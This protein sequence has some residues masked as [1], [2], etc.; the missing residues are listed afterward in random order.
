M[1][2]HTAQERKIK[3]LEKQ[4]EITIADYIDKEDPM[5]EPLSPGYHLNGFD[6]PDMYFIPQ[7]LSLELHVALW[8]IIPKEFLGV[9][10]NEY[11]KSLKFE[12]ASL[13]AHSEKAF[14]YKMYR[15]SI[16]TRRCIIPLKGFY[17]PHKVDGKGKSIPI[18]FNRFDGQSISVAGIY[19]ITKDGVATFTMFTKKATKWFGTIHN[20]KGDK[21]QIVL[22]PKYLEKEWLRNDLNEKHIKKIFSIQY[23][24]SE[25]ESRPIS[26]DIFSRDVESN[27]PDI[28][29]KFEYPGVN[30][31]EWNKLKTN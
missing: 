16:L 18:Y 12:G 26:R 20:K 30:I 2:F 21:R 11:Y 13:N 4:Y 23:N 25:L 1:C 14:T 22:L 3:N 28:I 29:D 19:S 31:E 15:D 24:E 27:R 6:H 9:K 8:G 7:E 5:G 17:E 10:Q